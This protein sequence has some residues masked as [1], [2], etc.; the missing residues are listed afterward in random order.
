MYDNVPNRRGVREVA[1]GSGALDDSTG[2]LSLSRIRNRTEAGMVKMVCEHISIPPDLPILSKST[3][4]TLAEA[5]EDALSKTK[6]RIDR[7]LS[8]LEDWLT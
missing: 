5:R 3:L 1:E 7:L 6:Q 2:N 4:R 8:S